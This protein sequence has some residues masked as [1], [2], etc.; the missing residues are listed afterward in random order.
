MGG[1]A[2]YQI[3]DVKSFVNSVRSSQCGSRFSHALGESQH[4]CSRDAALFR[5][6]LHFSG[7][8]TARF[9]SFS[10]KFA[11]STQDFEEYVSR[12]TALN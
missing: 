8:F 10:K 4:L 6:V 1:R 9:H 7:S 12:F 3:F 5:S 11:V 2:W